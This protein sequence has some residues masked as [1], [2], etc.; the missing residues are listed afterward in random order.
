M[1]LKVCPNPCA[2]ASAA[3]FDVLPARRESSSKTLFEPL[4]MLKY[5]WVF[6]LSCRPST[7]CSR[8]GLLIP[9]GGGRPSLSIPTGSSPSHGRSGSSR[10]STCKMQLQIPHIP[11][12]IQSSQSKQMPGLFLYV[13]LKTMYLPLR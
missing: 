13:I 4:E 12:K 1:E 3:E 7:L 9:S 2:F 6:P 8:Q 5:C 11:G 10:A